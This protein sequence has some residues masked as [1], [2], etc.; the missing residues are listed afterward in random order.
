MNVLN[1]AG[2]QSVT[3]QQVMSSELLCVYFNPNIH[4]KVKVSS[5]LRNSVICVHS[6]QQL[7]LTISFNWIHFGSTGL[8]LNKIKS[9]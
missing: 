4:F 1:S 3:S 5:P 8:N 6:V 2:P 7:K 9:I